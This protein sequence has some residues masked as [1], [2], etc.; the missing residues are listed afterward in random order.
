[1]KQWTDFNEFLRKKSL[2]MRLRL[3]NFLRQRNSKWVTQQINLS[4]HKNGYNLINFTNTEL[5]FGLIVAESRTLVLSDNESS[6][7]FV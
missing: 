2:V 1:M 6:E 7:I 4:K 5:D 3:I